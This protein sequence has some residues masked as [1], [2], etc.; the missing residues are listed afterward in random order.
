MGETLTDINAAPEP[1][2]L[3]LLFGGLV[4]LGLAAARKSVGGKPRASTA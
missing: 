1:V 2:S 4:G 3:S